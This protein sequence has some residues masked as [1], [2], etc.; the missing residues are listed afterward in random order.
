MDGFQ[1]QAI[2]T[3]SRTWSQAQNSAWT[4]KGW[5]PTAL[6]CAQLLCASQIWIKDILEYSLPGVLGPV[7]AP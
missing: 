7:L 6:I 4:I 1:I 3:A 5:P 2:N